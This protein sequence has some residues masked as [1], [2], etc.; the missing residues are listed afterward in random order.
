MNEAREYAFVW[1]FKMKHRVN[2]GQVI[3]LKFSLVLMFSKRSIAL[4]TSLIALYYILLNL[5][6]NIYCLFLL[7]RRERYI[8]KKINFF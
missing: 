2:N 1:I 8:K 6:F 3:I 4:K 5:R 7:P